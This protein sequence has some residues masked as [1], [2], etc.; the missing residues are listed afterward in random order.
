MNAERWQKAKAICFAVLDREP[1]QRSA[2]LAELCNGDA[3]LRREVVT[4][5]MDVLTDDG[6]YASPPKPNPFTPR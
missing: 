5:I 1:D 3:E 2:T 6:A 4:M